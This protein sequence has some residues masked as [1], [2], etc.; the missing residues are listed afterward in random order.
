MGLPSNI[1]MQ[2]VDFVSP[3]AM[4]AR[5]PRQQ[6]TCDHGKWHY[7][8]NARACV[9]IQAPWGCQAASTCKSGFRVGTHEISSQPNCHMRASATPTNHPR[10][11]QMAPRRKCQGL[12]GY[13]G[14]LGLLGS[15][16]ITRAQRRSMDV[17][18]LAV[19]PTQIALLGRKINLAGT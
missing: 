18:N 4:C 11:W 8:A 12:R 19:W 14:A 6:A 3:T 7:A 2:K 10:A 1:H 15:T 13:P 16:I 17:P 5:L 9:A